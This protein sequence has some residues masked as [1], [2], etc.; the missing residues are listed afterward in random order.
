LA[1]TA[2]LAE[3]HDRYSVP[4]AFATHNAWLAR[5]ERHIAGDPLP[6][7]TQAYV[8]NLGALLGAEIA[9]VRSVGRCSWRSAPI[10]I[11]RSERQ[12]IPN[13][14]QAERASTG[15][16]LSGHA[17][18]VEGYSPSERSVRCKI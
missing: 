16:S 11:E 3:L 18:L 13:R 8:T 5:Y 4:G 6:A 7:E 1:G 12:V 17:R 10:F 15:L 9:F 2:Y 14:L